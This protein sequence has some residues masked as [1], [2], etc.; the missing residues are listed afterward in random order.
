LFG[1]TEDFTKADRKKKAADRYPLA[2]GVADAK[3]WDLDLD[4]RSAGADE[5][6][7]GQILRYLSRAEV[8]SERRIQWAILTN[9]LHWRLYYQGAK[10]RLEEYF[11]V[12]IAWD[13]L[14]IDA[15]RRQFRDI[16][17]V[18]VLG[19]A[20]QDLAADR[21]IYLRCRPRTAL[22]L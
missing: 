12:D 17:D 7:S 14:E 10:S 2:I 4:R 11:E 5:T 15:G 1:S 3:A 20:R 18:L 9:G 13:F 21:R 8:Q 16:A 19:A 22:A 6:P